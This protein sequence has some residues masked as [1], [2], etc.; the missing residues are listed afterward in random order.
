MSFLYSLHGEVGRL[1]IPSAV[2]ARRADKL[3]EHTCFEAFV[4]PQEGDAYF[5]FNFAPSGEWAAYVF[6]RYREG[7]ALALDRTPAVSFRRTTGGLELEAIIDPGLLPGIHM[8]APLR[9]GLSAVIQDERGD[10]SYWALRH[11]S[12]RPDFHH[13]DAFVLVLNAPEHPGAEKT[14]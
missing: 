14:R 5:E 2:P 12:G 9:L 11:P 6:R 13:P 7:G 4:A 8:G 3:W 1:R 10:R